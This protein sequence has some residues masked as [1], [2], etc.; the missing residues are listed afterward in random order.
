MQWLEAHAL[1]ACGCEDI[2][3][4][5]HSGSMAAARHT[6]FQPGS[7]NNAGA[8]YPRRDLGRLQCDTPIHDSA[9]RSIA[10]LTVLYWCSIIRLHE[11]SI[12][13]MCGTFM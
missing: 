10:N 2:L 5:Q 8:L 12:V 3:P 11:C 4:R 13:T 1:F 7:E 6:P 9:L